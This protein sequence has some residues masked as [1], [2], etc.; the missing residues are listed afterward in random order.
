MADL[1]SPG[2]GA[3][4]NTGLGA[5]GGLFPDTSSGKTSSVSAGVSTG[6]TASNA[7]SQFQNFLNFLNTMKGTTTGT[8]TGVTTI[9]PNL[10]P[11][12][13]AYLNQL[14]GRGSNLTAPS[15]TGYQAQQTQNINQNADLQKQAVNNIMAIRGLANSPVSATAEAGV[16][17]NRINQITGMQEQLPMLKNQLDLQN[18]AQSAQIANMF[19]M[20]AGATQQTQQ[21]QQQD[22]SQ[23]QTGQQTQDQFAQSWQ[24]VFNFLQQFQNQWGTQQQSQG[25]GLGGALS[26][27]AQGFAAVLPFLLASDKKLKKNIKVLPQERAIEK[28]RELKAKTWDWKAND[29]SSVGVIAQELKQTLPELVE[30]HDNIKMVNYAGIIPYLIGAVQN[31]DSRME[32]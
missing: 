16:E 21:A 18:M 27:A 17:Q 7:S 24:N 14:I 20:L 3:A 19:P 26:G 12:M 29:A 5:L 31:L 32:A 28:I 11:Q 30:T 2:T 9:T 13:Q 6:N 15:L 23:T 8:G 10:T 25:G 1:M 4:I 22:T